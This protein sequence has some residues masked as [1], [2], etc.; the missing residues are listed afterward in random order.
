MTILSR[1]RLQI[2]IIVA[3]VAV[4]LLM[5]SPLPDYLTTFDFQA[6]WGASRLLSQSQNFTDPVLLLEIE[7]EATGFDQEVPLFA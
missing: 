5:P 7:Q 2:S 4:L 3:A 1:K 6:Y